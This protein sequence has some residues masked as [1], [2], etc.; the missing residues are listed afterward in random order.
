ML[1]GGLARRLGNRS[2]TI[3]FCGLVPFYV[4]P[5]WGHEAFGGRGCEN[6]AME[7]DLPR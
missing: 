6:S 4:E 5:A 2:E 7:A 3:K 1:A